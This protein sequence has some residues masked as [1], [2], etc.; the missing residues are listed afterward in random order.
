MD[1]STPAIDLVRPSPRHEGLSLYVARLVRSIW[2]APVAREMVT[3][4]G[5]LSISP[6]VSLGKLRDTQEDLTRLKEFLDTNKSFIEGLAGPGALGRV[7]SKQEEVTLQA[8]HRA[9]HALVVLIDHMIEGISFVLVLFDERIEEIVLSLPNDVRQ[10]VRSLTYEALFSTGNGRDLAKELVKAIV[11]RNIAQGSNVEVVAE[12]LRRRCGSFCSSDDVKIFK[13]QELVKRASEGGSDTEFGRNL[14]NESL[15]LFKQVVSTLSM[16][17]LQWAVQ[18]Y[19]SMQFYAGAIQ[20][21]LNVAQETD[22]GNRAL[23]W[24]QEGRPADVSQ[25]T[26]PQLFLLMVTGLTGIGFPVTKTMLQSSS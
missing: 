8:E 10:Q 25:V 17:Q 13:A 16:E 3:P 24:I 20:I 5:G 7:S 21:S 22:R 9:L 1:Q 6:A 19:V 11:N 15:S 14:L 2:K 18:Q 26:R 12:A 23:T 4:T